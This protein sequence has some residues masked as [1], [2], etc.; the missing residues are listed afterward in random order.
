MMQPL[1]GTLRS[2][3][4][5]FIFVDVQRQR[6][7]AKTANSPRLHLNCSSAQLDTEHGIIKEATQVV[8]EI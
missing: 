2:D 5:L 6:Q 7:R 3:W 4:S 8:G 1:P